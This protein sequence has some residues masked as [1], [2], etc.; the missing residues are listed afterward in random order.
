MPEGQAPV[1]PAPENTGGTTLL[2][3]APPAAAAAPAA[4]PAPGSAEAAVAAAQIEN[5]RP[6][7]AP[8]KFWDA[9]RR[10][11]KDQ[12]L[13]KAYMN[14]EKLVGR[15]KIP[16]PQ[17]DEDAEGWDRWYKASGRPEALDKYTFNRPKDIP[18]D[19][20]YDEQAE[21]DFRTWAF[22]NGL[23]QRQAASLYDGF[24]AKQLQSHAAYATAQRQAIEKTRAD[25]MRE[26]GAQYDGFVTSATTAMK[27]YGDPEFNKFLDET[28][29]G[30]HP[31]MIR[32]F[33]RVGKELA[34]ETRLQGKPQIT[35]NVADLDTAI[36]KFRNDN[37]AA[38]MDRSHPDHARLLGQ[39]NALFEKRYGTEPVMVR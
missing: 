8:E 15:E 22:A 11:L 16:V 2:T 24:V 35:E 9:D 29:L 32:V 25:L 34:G 19:L 36:T 31:A 33:G 17:S 1:A 27:Q 23:S 7:W 4:P 26:H 38:L 10:V 30:N 21:T 39:F 13:G 28:G 6:E 14:L 3:S 12:E 5:A 18:K 37:N 20:P